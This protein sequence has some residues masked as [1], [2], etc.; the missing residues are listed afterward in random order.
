MITPLDIRKIDGEEILITWDDGSRN[1]YPARI[2]RFFCP[3]AQC[4]DEHTG[5]RI[6]QFESIPETVSMLNFS[7]V[8]RYGVR[9][10]WSDGHQTGI[11]SFDY[12]KTLPPALE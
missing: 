1:L 5:E 11:Y 4:V 3:C 12:L 6:L 7:P 8:G 10:T 2:L 9:F